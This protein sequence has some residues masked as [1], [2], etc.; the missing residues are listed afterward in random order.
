ML[1]EVE[2]RPGHRMTSQREDD[3]K[4]GPLQIML[5]IVLWFSWCL[6]SVALDKYT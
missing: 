1:A 6:L 5:A 2:G 4:T 3:K